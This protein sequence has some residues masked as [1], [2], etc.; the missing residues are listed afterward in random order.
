MAIIFTLLFAVLAGWYDRFGLFFGYLLQEILR[1][2]KI[3]R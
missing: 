1:I 2:C 3:Q